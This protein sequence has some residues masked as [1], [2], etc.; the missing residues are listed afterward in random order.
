MNTLNIATPR[1]ANSCPENVFFQADFFKRGLTALLLLTLSWCGVPPALADY[2]GEAQTTIY[3]DKPTQNMIAARYQ[4]GG[5][6]QVG[7]VL[8]YIIQFT[9]V[10]GTGTELTG[11]G[12]YL[13]DYIP[14]GTQVVGAQFVQYNPATGVATQIAPPGPAEVLSILVPQY[15][16][17]GIFYSTDPRTAVFTNDGSSSISPI[18]GQPALLG[19]GG[20]P[21]AG[22]LF[23]IHNNWDYALTLLGYD[24]NP[25]GVTG[26]ATVLPS[27]LIP[28]AVAGPDSFITADTLGGQGPWQ[29]I[30][31]PGSTIGTAGGV[32]GPAGGCIGGAPTSIGWTLSPSSPLPSNVNAVRF[33]GGQTT[34]GQLFTV[35]I[36]LKLTQP[37][38]ATGLINN[39]EVYGGDVS[40]LA[41]GRFA[42][43]S[44][45]WRYVLPSVANA[46]TSLSVVKSIV[47]MCAPVAPA[48][49]CTIQP[50]SGGSVPSL[51]NLRLRYEITYLN[52]AATS[53]SNV[54][55][56]DILPP[57]P[58]TLLPLGTL[59][60]GSVVVVAGANISATT[61]TAQGF[62][63]APIASLGSGGGG[64][65]RF[66]VLF[67]TAPATGVP[68]PN[69]TTLTT[70]NL[71]GGVTSV[72]TTTPTSTASLTP[73]KTTS[74][75]AVAPSGL[76][77][78]VISVPNT[79]AAAAS[80]VTVTDTLPSDGLSALVA[81]RFSYNLGSAVASI[82]SASGVVSTI[83]PVTALVTAPTLAPFR[84]LVK[85]TLPNA[86]TIPAGATLNIS[87]SSLVG[88]S[89]PATASPYLND[90][91]VSY[92]GGATRAGTLTTA[93]ASGLAPVTVSVPLSLTK[94]IDCVYAGA[95]CV[96]YNYGSSIPSAS[97]VK[98]RLTYSNT[99]AAAIAGVVLKDTL[100]LNTSFVAAS[101]AEV[102]GTGF[103]TFG[104]VVQPGVAG[105]LLTFGTIAS[106]PAGATGAV[107]F[108]VQL[109]SAALIPSGTFITNKATV[110]SS[111]FTGGVTVNINTQV[112]DQAKLAVKK[113]T[114]TP[115]IA[116]GGTATYTITITNTGNTPASNIVVYD[117]L[118]YTLLDGFT[119]LATSSISAPMTAVVPTVN[120]PAAGVP[121]TQAA[122][123]LNTTQTEVIWN[124]G[125]QT[126][127]A[128]TSFTITF[129]AMP[130][131]TML[132][133]NTIYTN[134][135]LVNYNS[136]VTALLAGVV[137]TA[138]V[139]IPTNLTVSKTIDCVYNSLG[140]AC[141]A[142]NGSGIIPVNAK[143]RYK[144]SYK[145]TAA[146]AQT[147]VYICDQ[148]TSNQVTPLTATIS[149]PAI[150]PTPTGPYTNTP[151]VGIPTAPSN[152]LCG[153][154][155][156]PAAPL[157][158]VDFSYPV[159]TSLAAGATGVV[160]VDLAT[161][162]G[163]GAAI[164][165]TATVV[166]T[167]A[168][169][170]QSAIATASAL[171]VP[172]L[173]TAKT[174][175]TPSLPPGGAASYTISITNSGSAPT[176]ALKVY[177]F[178]PY[179]GTVVDATKRFT[180]TATTA[181]SK[182]GAAFVPTTPII[183][184]LSAPTIAP[185][186]ANVNQQQVLWDFGTIAA[187]QLAPGDT[188]TITFTAAIG[189]TMPTGA[190]NNSVGYEFASGSGPGS[191]NMNGLATLTIS[192]S[193]NIT[194]S[195][196]VNAFSD[197]INGT[198]NPLF[199][200]GGI[201]QYTVKASNAGGPVDNNTV[202]ITDSVPI[203]TAM[204][205]KDLGAP[206]SG[207]ILFVQGTPSS[208]LTYTPATDI[209]Y[210]GITPPATVAAWGYLPVA[211]A[212][213]CDPNVQQIRL[214]PKGIF[215][216]SATLPSPSF[217][218]N[219]RVCL[220]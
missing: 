160:Y 167:Q 30:S 28:S 70:T 121:P 210:L 14:A 159:I 26:C 107:T 111:L 61:A 5:A 125:T 146:T 175:S 83:A 20:G 126:L 71:P 164:N 34:V 100:P 193:P 41:T 219:F 143:V 220:Q 202:F 142:Y 76:A 204:Y 168:P 177:D 194:I 90:V 106:L 108:D 16:E 32:V 124:F 188:L 67:A 38:P 158:G 134:D 118:P 119:Y 154:V 116:V 131:A 216:G 2:V 207:P 187:N 209:S 199:I 113:T 23:S 63:F 114:S 11:G 92:Q 150:A 165:N 101:A 36:S 151:A 52:T 25:A 163:A 110:S 156:P 173:T 1:P 186:N 120:S 84:E 179:A 153:F 93:Y 128:G 22:S 136:G 88:S 137:K 181:Y 135:V 112:L 144:I 50:Y 171:N 127:A 166:S 95:V 91:Q 56:S 57:D 198:T 6:L 189:T 103:S 99:S 39:S 184:A 59:V 155:V 180:Y 73:N 21:P 10:P 130:G 133:G 140:T 4:A 109:G 44:N 89:V 60:P 24:A 86:T 206:G 58:V 182:N 152:A 132:A 7:D 18:N 66:D 48:T 81:D 82:T 197:P 35:K 53:Q 64:T 29:R 115:T 176:T 217:N 191:S 211:G 77:Q 15:A 72:A 12:A 196:V 74:T 123:A 8:S 192:S 104:T 149:Q 162:A 212:N 51:P 31:Y 147:N 218:F 200:P 201:A 43:K 49:T 161:N 145:N 54:Q 80:V 46:N 37:V 139:T 138:A 97:K 117:E 183:T 47:G 208:G 122:Y 214:N 40:I 98:Y 195:K 178:L 215:A 203:N 190:F 17:T 129:T 65:V 85:F 96:P 174:T 55:L 169:T 19:I 69:T 3:L 213:G 105:Q 13:T 87:F 170:G 68:L 79:G 185:Y 62:N 205:V 42:S 33:A 172:A 157:S 141:N 75:A 45:V 102:S 94:S 27:A 9:P 148:I 78:Y